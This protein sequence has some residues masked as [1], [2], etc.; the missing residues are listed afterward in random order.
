MSH[1]Q[2]HLKTTSPSPL[3]ACSVQPYPLR[4]KNPPAPLNSNHPKRK[5]PSHSMVFSQ[6]SQRQRQARP[7]VKAPARFATEGPASNKAAEKPMKAIFLAADSSMEEML[8][9]SMSHF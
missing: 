7:S 1:F 6:P 8:N 2:R 3:P 4:N 5:D 9:S